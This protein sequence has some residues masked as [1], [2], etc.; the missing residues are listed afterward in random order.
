M[1]NRLQ[2][3]LKKAK[4]FDLVEQEAYLNVLRTA[5]VLTA[6]FEQLFRQFKLSLTQYNV[7]RI[8]RGVGGPLPSGQIAERLVTR[9]PDITRLLDRLEKRGLI[10]R[11]RGE[12]D[13]RVV[14]A[15]ITPEGLEILTK[16][17][18]PVLDLH[19]AQLGHLGSE[20]LKTLIE[21]LEHARSTP[22]P[23]AAQAA[24]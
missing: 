24:E 2:A 1:P 23:L 17:D 15:S 6:G 19:R 12:A 5:Q 7:L 20:R 9:D 10:T 3:E 22:E 14:L 16:L 13:R 21:L 8:L 4:P 18:D 11:Q